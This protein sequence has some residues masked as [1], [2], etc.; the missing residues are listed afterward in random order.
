[1]EEIRE[2]AACP[3]IDVGLAPDNFRNHRQSPYERG[4]RI[5][6]PHT[7]EIEVEIGLA[8]IR[9]EQIDRLGTQQGF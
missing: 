7:Q 1:M 4:Q 8:S 6:D 5:G 2:P 3:V 9:I